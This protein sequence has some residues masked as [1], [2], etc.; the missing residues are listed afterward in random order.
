M[1]DN[2]QGAIQRK[3]EKDATETASP[4]R[5]RQPLLRSERRRLQ[6]LFPLGGNH[7]CHRVNLEG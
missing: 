7:P 3:I 1:T 4:R 6:K 5:G 2:N